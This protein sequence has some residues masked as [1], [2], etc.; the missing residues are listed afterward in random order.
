MGNRIEERIRK[1]GDVYRYRYVQE[2]ISLPDGTTDV[3]RGTVPMKKDKHENVRLP[4]EKEGWKHLRLLIKLR[5][6]M[7]WDK[8]N[9]I[10]RELLFA[11]FFEEFMTNHAEVENK[12]GEVKNKRKLAKYFLLPFLGTYFLGQINAKCIAQIKKDM[13]EM[14]NPRTGR[15]Y[16]MKYLNN[17]LTLLSTVLSIAVEWGYLSTAPKV[18]KFK[19]GIQKKMSYYT[20]EEATAIIDSA[21]GNWGIF[22]HLIFWYGLRSSEARALCWKD[23]DE[24]RNEIIIRHNFSDGV[25]GTPKGNLAKPIAL[26]PS[27]IELLKQLPRDGDFVFM[28]DNKHL[29]RGKLKWPLVRACRRAGVEFKGYHAFRRGLGTALGAVTSACVI[30]E[31]LRQ[32]DYKVAQKYINIS[33]SVQAEALRKVAQKAAL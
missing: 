5:E 20:I 18:K 7:Y 10:D 19:P 14:I 32:T 13:R 9:G 11:K 2:S 21:D 4:T 31:A 24:P 27:T 12:P 3:V 22:F 6:K 23:V 28:H 17:V 1:N 26:L 16:S 33:K 25:F 29:T 30:S 15:P 8:L